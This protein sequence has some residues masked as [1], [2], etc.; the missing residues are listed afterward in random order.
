M[1]VCMCVWQGGEGGEDGV[2]VV[3][4]FV[5]HPALPPCAVDGR[6]RNLLYYY[7]QN[8]YNLCMK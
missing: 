8:H 3:T 7:L 1:C 2:S 6:T 4:V 5:K